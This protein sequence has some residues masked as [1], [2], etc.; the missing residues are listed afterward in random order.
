LEWFGQN[1]LLLI[2]TDTTSTN[3]KFVDHL[4]IYSLDPR[5]NILSIFILNPD[6]KVTQA[7]IGYTLNYRTIM[8][9]RSIEGDKIETLIKS[10]ENL[11]ALKIDRYI[12]ADKNTFANF[13]S[14]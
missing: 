10:V 2:G 13:S 7:T 8:N 11:L 4:S 12:L 3:H 9:N 5:E 1:D 6:I 14:F